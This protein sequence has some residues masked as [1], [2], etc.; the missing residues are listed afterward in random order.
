MQVLLQETGLLGNQSNTYK[1]SSKSKQEIINDNTSYSKRLGFKINEQEKELPIMYWTPKMHK[2]PCGKR[3]IVASKLCSTKQLSKSIS[4]V[5]KLMYHQI[6]NFHKKAK[7]LSNY[8]KFWVLQ[9]SDPVINSMNRINKKCNA[10]SISTFDFS[11]LYTKLPHDKLLHVLFELIDFVFNGGNKNYIKVSKNGKAYWGKNTSRSIGFSKTSL[12][13]AVKHLIENCFFTI[14]NATLRQAIGIPMGIDPAPFWAN[15]FLYFYE[16]KHISDLISS[17][18]VKARHFH[19]TMRFIDDLCAINDGGQF[20]HCHE[21]IYPEELE[22]KMEHTGTKA[23]FLNL[24][25]H[26]KDG[27]FIYKLF[28]K[29]DSFPF[30][31]V[32]MPHRNSN[33]PKNIFYSAL[34]GEMLRITRST[35]QYIDF[36]PK[37]QE[38][39]KRMSNQGAEKRHCYFSLKKLVN[40]HTEDFSKYGI[41]IELL[42]N[43]M[44][45]L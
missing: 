25:I 12:K 32:R 37:A 15:L 6:E 14:G 23:T 28:D 35:L 11:T 39:V 18:K 44:L 36:L 30:F 24:D 19:S 21:N 16:E 27:K 10:K 13:V 1:I 40:K 42:L 43:E 17:D 5:F 22:L 9:N 3:F 20:G 8:N 34:V 4:S 26:I 33:I 38:L 2:D 29:R 41:N 31:I 7:F 45:L